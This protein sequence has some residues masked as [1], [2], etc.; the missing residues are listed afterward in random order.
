MTNEADMR[1]LH[2]TALAFLFSTWADDTLYGVHSTKDREEL[3]QFIAI[4]WG[5]FGLYYD[6]LASGK[7][8]LDLEDAESLPLLM[9]SS[10]REV[11]HF[12]YLRTTASP[13]QTLGYSDRDTFLFGAGLCEFFALFSAAFAPIVNPITMREVA[14]VCFGPEIDPTLEANVAVD[15]VMANYNGMQN[16]ES[17][18]QQ[19]ALLYKSTDDAVSLKRS[20]YFRMAPVFGEMANALFD[21][22]FDGEDING[23]V[24]AGFYVA[25][26]AS[27]NHKG[28][29][30][31]PRSKNSGINELNIFLKRWYNT[32]EQH[33]VLDLVDP[34]ICEY[35]RLLVKQVPAPSKTVLVPVKVVDEDWDEYYDG[36]GI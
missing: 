13:Q 27:F 21:D 20:M 8:E 28:N 32:F 33:Q 23:W 9:L 16:F 3:E 31:K 6:T 12:E 25:F 1:E 30:P 36:W 15:K 26:F 5:L 7:T 11:S 19:L 35:K 22:E 34:W 4:P 14:G 24:S 29:K 18:Y 2:I 10:L 17:M